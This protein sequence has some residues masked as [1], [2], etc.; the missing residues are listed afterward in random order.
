[1]SKARSPRRAGRGKQQRNTNCNRSDRAATTDL[2]TQYPR[3]PPSKDFVMLPKIVTDNR[4][5]P[6]QRPLSHEAETLLHQYYLR[7][8]FATA[9]EHGTT[10]E[11]AGT[12]ILAVGKTRA[13][14]VRDEVNS[15]PL[16]WFQEKAIEGMR[17]G[18]IGRGR[19]TQSSREANAFF[20]ALAGGKEGLDQIKGRIGFRRQLDLESALKDMIDEV[21]REVLDYLVHSNLLWESLR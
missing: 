19:E 20:V 5:F 2:S 11:W 21:H 15:D 7:A 8:M 10:V 3:W 1:M 18:Q 9:L 16:A 12:W 13:Y 4:P 14:Q 17:S 6:Q